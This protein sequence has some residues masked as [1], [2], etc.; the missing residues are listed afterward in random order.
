MAEP[1]I[2]LGRGQILVATDSISWLTD[3]YEVEVIP[4]KID[5]EL[6]ESYSGIISI[7]KL[8][9][10]H[11]EV[12]FKVLITEE[13]SPNYDPNIHE[14]NRADFVRR[15]KEFLE[16]ISGEIVYVFSE[17]FKPFQGV[18][19]TREYSVAEGET[20]SE[21]KVTIKEVSGSAL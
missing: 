16:D 17:M 14:K 20:A 3:A 11:T 18:I 5:F 10:I 9:D 13:K 2:Q 21:Y 4:R 1:T 8:L 19:T 15:R 12:T 7:R 6:F